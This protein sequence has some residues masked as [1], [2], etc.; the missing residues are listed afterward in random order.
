[1]EVI[2]ISKDYKNTP[3]YIR[4]KILKCTV[5][6]GVKECDGTFEFPMLEGPGCAPTSAT[7]HKKIKVGL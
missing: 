5:N 6:K 3:Y 2:A 7:N 4:S 1:M